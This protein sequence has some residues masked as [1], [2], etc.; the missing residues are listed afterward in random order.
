MSLPFNEAETLIEGKKYFSSAF[1]FCFI[2]AC[3]LSK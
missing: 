2:F 1:T 3:N